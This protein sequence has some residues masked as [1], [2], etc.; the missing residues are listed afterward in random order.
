MYKGY[1][2][3]P[4]PSTLFGDLVSSPSYY[5][6]A[7]FGH[8]SKPVGL[9]AGLEGDDT[10]ITGDF[11]NGKL[12]SSQESK[13]EKAIKLMM[14]K[15]VQH[16]VEK[17]KGKTIPMDKTMNKSPNDDHISEDLKVKIN[18]NYILVM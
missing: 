10:I 14:E 8:G 12:E 2:R 11:V 4:Y 5:G 3:V 15:L 7:T 16:I 18:Y 1:C 6:H 13:K 9:A 17:G